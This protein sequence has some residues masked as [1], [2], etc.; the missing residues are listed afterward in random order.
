MYL[1]VE[2]QLEEEKKVVEEQKHQIE[3]QR[4]E[5]KE[6]E[7]EIEKKKKELDKILVDL[8]A[9]RKELVK[10]NDMIYL[11]SDGFADQF[12]GE[13]NKKYNYKSFKQKLVEISSDSLEEQY[14]HLHI[15]FEE[16]K[17]DNEQIDD[18]LVMGIRI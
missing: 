2:K 10:K 16:W 13:L 11:F 18:V 1:Q 9:Q 8:Q 17:G 15:V 6:L 12:G 14:N 3:L 4:E 7:S 5:I